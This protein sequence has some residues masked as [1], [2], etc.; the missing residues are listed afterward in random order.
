MVDTKVT[1]ARLTITSDK[2]EILVKPDPALDYKLGKNTDLGS[3]L[4]AEEIYS[5]ANKE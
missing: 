3:V 1:T 5:D 2:F 4:V